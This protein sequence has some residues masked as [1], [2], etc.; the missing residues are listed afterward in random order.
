MSPQ[1]PKDQPK[2]FQSQSFKALNAEWEAKLKDS[3]FEDIERDENNLKEY[4]SSDFKKR[5]EYDQSKEEYYRLA[6]QFFHDYSFRGP[7][8]EWKKRVW[9]LH[10][11]GKSIR[12]II[13][14]L[15]PEG[16]EP[17]GK[18]F[19]Q[20]QPAIAKLAKVMVKKCLKQHK[21]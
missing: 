16:K 3:G 7:N 10:A 17:F 2:F 9:G 5:P 18:L 1:D 8:R 20:I 13:K 21:S 14:I 12:E 19:K 6:G 4:A 15:D 11:E